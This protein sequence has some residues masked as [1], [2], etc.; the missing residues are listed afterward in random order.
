MMNIEPLDRT[1]GSNL[2][3][4]SVFRE[5][6]LWVF[7]KK[8]LPYLIVTLMAVVV[9]QARWFMV[10]SEAY[11]IT[12]TAARRPYYAIRDMSYDDTETMEKLRAEVSDSIV[13]VLVKGP[14]KN[15]VGFDDEC[16]ILLNQPL[17]DTLL[18]LE[19]R[20]LIDHMTLDRR[21]LLIATVRSIRDDLQYNS[22]F[23]K[24]ERDEFIW[25]KIGLMESDPSSGN[26]IFQILCALADGDQR[27]DPNLTESVR[28]LAASD[29]EYP[30]KIFYAGDRI[31]DSG[32]VVT[33]EIASLLRLQGYPEGRYP[34]T[35]LFFA[36]V[37]A[38]VCV[39]WISRTMD[40]E[41]M[42]GSY[43]GEWSYP[44]FLPVLGWFFEVGAAYWGMYGVGL[45]P[46]IAII[47]LTLPE[48]CARSCAAATFLSASMVANGYDVG[49]FAVSAIA[50]CAGA[51][52]GVSLFK[53]NFSRSAVW[54]HSLLLG[55]A[56]FFVAVAVSAGLSHSLDFR[57]ITM[58]ALSV[59]M[60][61]FLVL[62]LLPMLEF[63]FDV[64][65]PLRLVELTQTSQPL[66]RQMQ[67][68]APGTYNH[69]QM[70]GNLA[71]AAAE[72]IGLNP[73]LLRAG[74]CFHDIGKLK[75]P[76]LFVENQGGGVNGHDDMSPALSAM[77]ILSHVKD[78]LELAEEF[79]L[80]SQI[81]AFIAEH[82]GTGCLSYF[83][84]KALQAG[85][86]AEE[87][88]FCYPGPKPQSRETG[89][90]MLADSTEAAA[91]AE[92][93]HLRGLHDLTRLVD[94]VVDS[95]IVSGQLDDVPFTFSDI[96]AIKSAMVRTLASMYHTRNIKPLASLEIKKDDARAHEG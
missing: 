15:Q 82:H 50:G 78:G 33:P 76:G 73:M 66:L 58:G 18:P 21:E 51:I 74:A 26:I 27:I 36:V 32:E 16:E 48:G 3:S 92:S 80:P 96:T 84:K 56:M 29:I 61:S 1:S 19:L 23:T 10:D 11:F 81:R 9:V 54:V 53:R 94:G 49:A 24:D 83:Y 64:V 55:G 71:E 88:Q 95:K 91:R 40:D 59:L 41:A 20:E 2:F 86:N 8:L 17:E 65:S 75:R 57:L 34:W 46:I 7:G 31:V 93:S 14:M 63:V 30:R 52:L 90:L 45:F 38:W 5:P 12:G 13:G 39:F 6:A 43:Y 42:G 70:V 22:N 47:Y 77:I 87:S 35:A 69:S 62:V 72:V 85:L 37:V 28:D 67:V 60:L 25:Q 44:F 79:H 68:E 89:V 4:S